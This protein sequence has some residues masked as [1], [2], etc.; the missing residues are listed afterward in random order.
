MF[1]PTLQTFIFKCKPRLTV[2]SDYPSYS[3]IPFLFCN[4][5]KFRPCTHYNGIFPFSS[6]SLTRTTFLVDSGST[7]PS[8]GS[9]LPCT[10][11]LAS[12]PP[13]ILNTVVWVIF[14][15]QHS[16]SCYYAYSGECMNLDFHVTDPHCYL[17]LSSCFPPRVCIITSRTNSIYNVDTI[18]YPYALPLLIYP[19]L[20][21]K[22]LPKCNLS[23][24]LRS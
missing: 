14:S 19:L 10:H 8:V 15:H 11:F 16:G 21:L 23:S 20:F 6:R 3:R 18:L 24:S 17:V 12:P 4:G 13:L 9:E 2:L 7:N 1:E 5:L 22:S